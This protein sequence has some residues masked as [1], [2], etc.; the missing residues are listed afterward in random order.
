MVTLSE[1]GENVSMSW[2]NLK[3]RSFDFEGRSLGVQ[4]RNNNSEIVARLHSEKRYGAV[5]IVQ[6]KPQNLLR[7]SER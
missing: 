7:E 4:L 3:G 1:V 5:I 6:G 2:I